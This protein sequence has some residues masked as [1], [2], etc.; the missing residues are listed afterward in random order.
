MEV[1]SPVFE[2]ASGGVRATS[3]MCGN[4][5]WTYNEQNNE[6]VIEGNGD[7]ESACDVSKELANRV[8]IVTIKEGVTSVADN[9]FSGWYIVTSATIP[10]GVRKIGGNG[11][12]STAIQSVTIPGSVTSVGHSAFSLCRE[13]SS[14]TISEGGSKD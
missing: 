9:A 2:T 4:L 11:F 10:E 14:L 8:S 12:F 6:I 13:L 3:L 5:T 1:R 7:M